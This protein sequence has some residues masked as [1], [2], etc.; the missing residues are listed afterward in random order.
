MAV[1]PPL[2]STT[3]APRA[4]LFALKMMELLLRK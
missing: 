2:E 3:T 1:K 4:R